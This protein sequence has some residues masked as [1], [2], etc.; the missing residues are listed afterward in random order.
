[1]GYK[2]L[3]EAIKEE[4]ERR[5]RELWAEAEKKADLIR[6]ETRARIEMLKKEYEE[7]YCTEVERKRWKILRE[8]QKKAYLLRLEIEEELSKR[9][10]NLSF[11][12]LSQ[13]RGQ[14]YIEIFSNLLKEL[15]PS[16]WIT[17]KVNPED[18][19]LAAS[20]FPEAEI[21]SDP[22]ISG[23]YVTINRDGNVINNTFEKRL[24]RLWQHIL[25]EIIKNVR[26]RCETPHR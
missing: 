17:V 5:I 3:I 7:R 1:M 11:Q 6:E 2:E 16:N 9:L 20:H 12:L 18:A 24:E 23:G 10:F 22:S 14:D 26:E 13:L 19:G 8:A 15:P 21:V 25:P 4:G